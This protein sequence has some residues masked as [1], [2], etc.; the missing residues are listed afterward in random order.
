MHPCDL[1]GG[2]DSTPLP[3]DPRIHV[4]R[5]CG[6]VYVRERRPPAEVAAAWAEVYA[7]GGYDPQWPGVQA[8]LFYVASWIRENIG[9][10]NKRLLDIGA[11]DGTFLIYAGN[12]A[13]NIGLHG[14]EPTAAA[15][16][17]WPPDG[18][19]QSSIETAPADLGK[20]DLVTINW[21]LENTSDCMAML[22]FAREH[23]KDDGHVVVATGSRILVPFKKPLSHYL[24]PDRPADL[25]CYRWSYRTLFQAMLKAGLMPVKAND[26]E[27]R[28]EVVLAA[29]PI[30]YSWGD[31]PIG[32][33]GRDHPDDVLFFF[34]NWQ[35]MWP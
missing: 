26:Y 32:T 19:I 27:D 4:C 16:T 20:F 35:R 10:D 22:R 24:A 25:H 33:K 1:C 8:R 15:P 2:A 28:D 30:H 6:F 9:L 18:W 17:W 21:T 29:K 12:N 5:G 23:V 3:Q 13:S 7:S 11:G 31:V 34:A 14:L